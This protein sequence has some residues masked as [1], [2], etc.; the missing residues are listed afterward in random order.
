MKAVAVFPRERAVRLIDIP[1]PRITQAGEVKLRTLDVGVCGTDREICG[2]HYGT[3]PQGSDHL[4]IGH[5]CLGEVVEVG[6]GVTRFKKGDLAVLTVRRPC[7]V[8]ECPSCAEGRQD[9]CY[10]GRFTERGIKQQHG[11]MTEYVVD[12]QEY[13]IPVPR[14]L[15]E[16]AVL[17]EPLTIAEKALI[18]VWQIQQRLPWSCPQAGGTRKPGHCHHA[19]VLGAGPI[20]LLG[21]MA[22]ANAGF[23]TFVY[24]REDEKSE[25]AELVRSFGATYVSSM[26]TPV[27]KLVER[28]GTIDVV[29]E[30]TGASKLSFEVLKQV[31][32]NAAFVFTGVPGLKGTSEIDTDTIM[33]NMVLKNQVLLGTVNAGHDAFEAAIRDL[34]DFLTKWPAAIKSL[35]TAQ[36]PAVEFKQPLLSVEGIKNVIRFG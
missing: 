22:F 15:R 32:P 35:I 1:E 20:G 6:A 18:E 31:G 30:A 7:G 3:P 8:A 13:M 17:V 10:T 26:V 33:R 23:S 11:Y 4:I 27:D 29:Y 19:L 28:V 2:F 16:V 9:F 25:K 24:S 21:A 5:E 34:G 12:S 14:E 36:Y